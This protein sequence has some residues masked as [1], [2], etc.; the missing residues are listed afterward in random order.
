MNKEKLITELLKRFEKIFYCEK[1]YHQQRVY[2]EDKYMDDV[3]FIFKAEYKGNTYIY[4]F[5]E[6]DNYKEYTVYRNSRFIIKVSKTHSTISGD[7]KFFEEFN[8]KLFLQFNEQ[9][10]KHLPLNY[11]LNDL[12]N[13]YEII[14]ED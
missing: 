5:R 6:N 13:M 3:S 12:E 4:I 10:T 11:E 9:R 7:I 1:L 2:P 14:L 8:K